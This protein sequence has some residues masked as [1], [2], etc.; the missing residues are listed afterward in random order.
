MQN[1]FSCLWYILHL[2]LVTDLE[3]NTKNK[4]AFSHTKND[5]KSFPIFLNTGTFNPLSL[6]GGDSDCAA[7][8]SI[9]SIVYIN[10]SNH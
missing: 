9:G 10:E 7:I 1:N 5:S 3:D 8:D 4:L 2:Y 6:F